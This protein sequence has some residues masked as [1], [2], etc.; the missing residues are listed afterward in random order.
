MCLGYAGHIVSPHR[1]SLST[2]ATSQEYDHWLGRDQS[3]SG[4]CV[5]LGTVIGNGPK[6]FS[7]KNRFLWIVRRVLL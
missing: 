7:V 1:A 3:K 5:C 2:P 4:I 6:D